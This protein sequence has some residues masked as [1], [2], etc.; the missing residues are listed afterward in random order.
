[1]S[2]ADVDLFEWTNLFPARTGL[3]VTLWVSVH[4]VVATDPYHPETIE[5]DEAVTAWVM[6]NSA[7]LLAHFI[8]AIDGVEMAMRTKRLPDVPLHQRGFGVMDEPRA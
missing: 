7:A 1:M 6:L 4:G 3:P 2:A 5:H 8:G